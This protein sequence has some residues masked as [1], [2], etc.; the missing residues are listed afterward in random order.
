MGLGLFVHFGLYSQSAVGEWVFSRGE[1]TMEEYSKLQETFT[2]EDFD[3]E[4]WYRLL[5]VQ[6][7][8]TSYSRQDIMRVFLCL[9]LR[10]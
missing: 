1:R 10:V 7:V 9:M 4:N 3:A 2:A 5:N 8:N 6:G